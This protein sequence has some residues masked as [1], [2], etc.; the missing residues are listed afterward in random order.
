[1]P[2]TVKERLVSVGSPAVA[3]AVAF[4]LWELAVK[5]FAVKP[6]FLP[7]PSGIAAQAWTNRSQLGGFFWLT[8]KE[9]ILGLLAATA[10]ATFA[11][12][13]VHR[14]RTAAQ[15][16]ASIAG[17][18]RAM[19]TVVLYPIVTVFLGTTSLA[20]QTIIAIA[21]AP[22]VFSYVLEGLTQKS[23]LDELMHVVGADRSQT[24]WKVRVP[25]AT[26][27]L[28]TGI[29]TALPLSV[30]TAIVGEYFGGSTS[31]LGAHIRLMAQQLHTIDL[32]AAIVFACLLGVLAF[33]LGALLER[34]LAARSG[35]PATT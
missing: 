33:V 10:V 24:F 16:S 2:A 25:L 5:A 23:D 27:H 14:S 1:M 7:A 21:L 20:V 6:L 34:T 3:L 31:T 19:P 35:V 26:P 17:A 9:A 11:A 30:I 29:R 32:W 8:G 13:L 4:A 15:L 28:L 12:V 18:G 22:L